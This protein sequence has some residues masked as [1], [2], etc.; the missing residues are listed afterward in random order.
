MLMAGVVVGGRCHGPTE[1]WRVF[2]WRSP[3]PGAGDQDRT[4]E[5]VVV[6]RHSSLGRSV[7][8]SGLRSKS[9]ITQAGR[10]EREEGSAT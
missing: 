7:C 4:G 5:V 10:G 9:T 2:E 8:R 6:T 1:V 3:A